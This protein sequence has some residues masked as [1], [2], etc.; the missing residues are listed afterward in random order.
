M[1]HIKLG[2][3]SGPVNF[4]VMAT[5]MFEKSE[6]KPAVRDGSPD[7]GFDTGVLNH[8]G[9]P[10]DQTDWHGLLCRKTLKDGNLPA[11]FLLVPVQIRLTM[12]AKLTGPE[13]KVH[14]VKVSVLLPISEE[15][16]R[17]LKQRRKKRS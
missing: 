11:V 12:A 1:T 5:I 15:A 9:C 8:N 16:D 4:V 14:P 7:K 3:D 2:L 13:S 10:T 17:R 6:E